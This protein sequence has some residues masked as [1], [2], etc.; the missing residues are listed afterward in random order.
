M[1]AALVG[2]HAL[3]SAFRRSLSALPPK[4]D[5]RIIRGRASLPARR[6]HRMKPTEAHTLP[7]TLGTFRCGASPS[8]W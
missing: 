7:K 1:A 6:T 3:K 2:E 8:A 4:P 5:D